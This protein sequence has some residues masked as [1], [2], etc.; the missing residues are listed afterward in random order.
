MNNVFNPA[1]IIHIINPDNS[2]SSNGYTLVYDQT[3][4]MHNL[5]RSEYKKSGYTYEDAVKYFNVM[6]MRE[7]REYH[8]L[9]M[10]I[11]GN[12]EYHGWSKIFMIPYHYVMYNFFRDMI[13]RRLVK[14]IQENLP[15]YQDKL[16]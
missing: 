14:A 16:F 13:T 2:P 1:A 11:V 8:L 5:T 3:K 9:E 7:Y 4:K 15:D 12:M 10:A 6:F